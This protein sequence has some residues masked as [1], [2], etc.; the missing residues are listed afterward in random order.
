[1]DIIFVAIGTLHKMGVETSDIRNAMYCVIESNFTKFPFSKT[2]DGKVKKS[3]RF[4][5]PDL[6]W[7]V[8]VE[9]VFLVN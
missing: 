8:P 3:D 9:S 2:E 4:V 6:K 1:M 7:E 5:P